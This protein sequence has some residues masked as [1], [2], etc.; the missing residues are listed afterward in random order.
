MTYIYNMVSTPHNFANASTK[1]LTLARTLALPVHS[2][3]AWQNYGQ[4]SKYIF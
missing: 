4:K 3:D 2:H 1:P